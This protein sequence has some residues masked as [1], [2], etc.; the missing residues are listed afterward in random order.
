MQDKCNKARRYS[1][2]ENTNRQNKQKENKDGTFCTTHKK[3]EIFQYSD[4]KLKERK[5]E[6]HT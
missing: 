1:E 3:E 2:V 4:L 6:F 5:I